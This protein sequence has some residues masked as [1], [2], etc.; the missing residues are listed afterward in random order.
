MGKLHHLIED[1]QIPEVVRDL[2]GNELEEVREELVK[3]RVMAERRE[4]GSAKGLVGVVDD[5]GTDAL[6]VELELFRENVLDERLN[7]NVIAVADG[8]RKGRGLRGALRYSLGKACSLSGSGILWDCGLDTFYGE[9]MRWKVAK[10]VSG[11]SITPIGTRNWTGRA[12][13]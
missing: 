2:F 4:G 10:S 3:A 9:P 12:Y 6:K 7:G 1:E 11:A 13:Q 5:S 8:G